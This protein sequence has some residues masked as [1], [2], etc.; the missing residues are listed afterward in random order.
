MAKIKDVQLAMQGEFESTQNIA[1]E[2]SQIAMDSAP[3]LTDKYIIY[4]LV[5]TDKKG[6]VYIDGIDDVINPTTKKMERIWL[7][8]GASSIWASDLVE[9]LKDKDYVRQNRRSLQFEAGVLRVPEWDTLTLDFI[10]HCRHL[11]DNPNRRTGS[12]MEFFEYNPAKQQ[13]AALKKEMLEIEMALVAKNMDMDKVKKLA[14]FFGIVFFDDLGE[15]KSADGI[16]TDLML[17]AKRNPVKF[18]QNLDSKEIEVA[19]LIKR[20]IISSKIDLGSGNGIVSWANGGQIARIPSTQSPHEFLLTLAMS[21]S[22]EGETFLEQL[23]RV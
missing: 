13:E 14:S 21:R 12:K 17:F 15:P 5:K 20:A 19:Y 3:Q 11:I 10:K 1:N 2:I 23:Q 7:L 16:R 6:R 4:K 22:E 18:Q 8:S 9:V